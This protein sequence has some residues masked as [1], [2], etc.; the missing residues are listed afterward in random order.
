MYVLR[1]MVVGVPSCQAERTHVALRSSQSPT[2]PRKRTGMEAT[3][4]FRSQLRHVQSICNLSLLI[5]QIAPQDAGLQEPRRSLPPSARP[6]ALGKSPLREAAGLSARKATLGV[7]CA[8]SSRELTAPLR[9]WSGAHTS[10]RSPSADAAV[11]SGMAVP[12]HR[13]AK[14]EPGFKT[15]RVSFIWVLRELSR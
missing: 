6:D 11:S 3:A 15:T 12:K 1:S 4:L 2:L 7:Q 8:A 5:P 9:M 10:Q 13:C 14:R